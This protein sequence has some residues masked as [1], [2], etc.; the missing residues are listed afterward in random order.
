M[1]RFLQRRM[2]QMQQKTLATPSAS[3]SGPGYVGFDQPM[4]EY[5]GGTAV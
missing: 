2:F 5:T 3:S 1:D 4:M